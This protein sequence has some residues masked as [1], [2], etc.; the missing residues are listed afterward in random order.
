MAQQNRL[1]II[2]PAGL[3]IAGLNS[4]YDEYLN[5]YTS[6]ELQTGEYFAN[7]PGG[8]EMYD[9]GSRFYDPQV[10]RWFTPDPAEQFHNPYLAMGNN[11]INGT[12]PN[13]EWF[14]I[15]SWVVGFVHGFFSSGSSRFDNA[16][17]QANLSAGNGFSKDYKVLQLLPNQSIAEVF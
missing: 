3:S 11:P 13:G 14:I 2:I 9:F 15:D 10:G 16:W 5:K 1:I 12:D 8:L 17:D 7:Q 4:D 6:K